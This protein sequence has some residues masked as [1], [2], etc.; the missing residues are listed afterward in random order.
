MD[1]SVGGLMLSDQ[2]LQLATRLPTTNVYGFGENLHKSF[3]HP[4]DTHPHVYSAFARDL[5]PTVSYES[6]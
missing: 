6:K 3:K 5:A 1:T 2:Y 4:F